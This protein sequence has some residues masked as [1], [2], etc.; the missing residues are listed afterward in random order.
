MIALEHEV[1]REV[2]HHDIGVLGGKIVQTGVFLAEIAGSQEA[3]EA[4]QLDG[5]DHALAFLIDKTHRIQRQRARFVVAFHHGDLGGLLLGNHGGRGVCRNQQAAGGHE[6]NSNAGAQRLAR[7]LGMLAL[8]HIPSR[9][10]N[11]HKR[12]HNQQGQHGVAVARQRCGVERRS[13]EIGQHGLG[14]IGGK[15]GTAGRLH[16]GV[17]DDDPQGRKAAAQPYQPSAGQVELGADLAATEEHDAQE[18]RLEEEREQGLG[19]QRRAEDVAHEA[20][21][22]SPVGAKRELHGDA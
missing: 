2:L 12:A 16:P 6:R 3:R 5:S 22:I 9:N 1:N 14:A 15:L 11:C 17:G 4:G 8:V 19:G 21:V 10:R 20:T 13:E 18:H 7:E